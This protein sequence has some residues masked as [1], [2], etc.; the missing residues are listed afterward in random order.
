MQANPI[1]KQQLFYSYHTGQTVS[2]DD[3]HRSNCQ[4]THPVEKR[5]ILLKQSFTFTICMSP[6]TSDVI[7]HLNWGD[8]RVLNSVVYSVYGAGLL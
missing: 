5:R 1:H 2:A 7:L 4:L 3:I 8:A 6:L